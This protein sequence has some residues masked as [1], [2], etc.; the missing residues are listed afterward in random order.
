M[1]AIDREKE[2]ERAGLKA[3]RSRL[4]SA[5]LKSRSHRGSG[6][7]QQPVPPTGKG[8][9]TECVGWPGTAEALEPGTP[10]LGK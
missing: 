9:V 4:A 6:V 2:A 10:G 1:A 7:P 3:E 8:R 5:G